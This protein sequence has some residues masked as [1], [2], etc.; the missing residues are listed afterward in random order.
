MTHEIRVPKKSAGVPRE[1]RGGTLV[2]EL[3]R[4]LDGRVDGAAFAAEV[5]EVQRLDPRNDG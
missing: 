1:E 2:S 4:A 3:C 5:E